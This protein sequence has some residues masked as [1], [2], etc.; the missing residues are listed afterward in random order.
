[1]ARINII[2]PKNILYVSNELE[3]GTVYLC[4]QTR[5]LKKR[6]TMRLQQ[7]V[8]N[9]SVRYP[10]DCRNSVVYRGAP[11]KTDIE[12]WLS[13]CGANAAA[14]AIVEVLQVCDGK[15]LQLLFLQIVEI[16]LDFV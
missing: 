7:P 4:K 9:L 2:V 15:Y 16:P 5:V 1:M 14:V 6:R 3:T 11:W 12:R 13:S 8:V 10:A